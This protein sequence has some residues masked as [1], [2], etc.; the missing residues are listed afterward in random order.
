MLTY[1]ASNANS[2]Y[3]AQACLNRLRSDLGAAASPLLHFHQASS[4]SMVLDCPM[5]FP[6]PPL[7]P[8]P[9]LLSSKFEPFLLESILS[10]AWRL[11]RTDTLQGGL[12]P[13]FAACPDTEW[14]GLLRVAISNL[15][16]MC[17]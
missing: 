17:L 1:Q 16:D 13:L 15:S 4:L 5:P 14:Q 2:V 11:K 10:S 6:N 8:S 12:G 3:V 7:E 9:K